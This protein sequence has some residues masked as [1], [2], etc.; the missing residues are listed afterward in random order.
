MP[1]TIFLTLAAQSTDCNPKHLTHI[2]PQIQSGKGL[3]SNRGHIFFKVSQPSGK[4]AS[5]KK[6]A[7]GLHSPIK[8]EAD[9]PA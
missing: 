5:Y 4:S 9:L 6:P 7:S 1:N 2:C 3:T 8:G